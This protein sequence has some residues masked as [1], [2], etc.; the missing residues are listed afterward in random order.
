[1]Q[2]I[3]QNKTQFKILVRQQYKIGKNHLKKFGLK[4]VRVYFN[5]N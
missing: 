5:D 3:V 2:N 1:M 4:S